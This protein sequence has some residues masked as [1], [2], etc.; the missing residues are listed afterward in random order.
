MKGSVMY[1]VVTQNPQTRSSLSSK[2]ACLENSGKPKNKN[3]REKKTE[4]NCPTDPGTNT[5]I[6]N[7][8]KSIHNKQSTLYQNRFFEMLKNLSITIWWLNTCDYTWNLFLKNLKQEEL[9]K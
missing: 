6:I 5:E 1:F 4:I 9:Q 7:E 2:I 8:T 3:C